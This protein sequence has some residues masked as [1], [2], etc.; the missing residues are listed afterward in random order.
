[1]Q[2]TL[3]H[4]QTTTQEHNF[5]YFNVFELVSHAVK[6]RENPMTS[7]IL[8]DPEVGNGTRVTVGS[9]HSTHS[10]YGQDALSWKS[11]I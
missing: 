3:S 10:K 2:S 1:M 8:L 4:P 9:L 5:A 7:P 6:Q 11:E